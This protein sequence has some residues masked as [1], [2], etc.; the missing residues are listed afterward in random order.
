MTKYNHKIEDKEELI[1]YDEI[2]SIKDII[3]KLD[4]KT[5]IKTQ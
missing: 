5:I 3:S 1:K 4:S 2:K